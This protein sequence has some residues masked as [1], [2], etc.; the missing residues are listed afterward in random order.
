MAVFRPFRAIRPLPEYASGV[1]ELPY[2][3][4]SSDEARVRA[5][6]RPYSFLHVDKAEIDLP[7]DTDLYSEQVYRKAKE[8]MEKLISDGICAADGTPCYYIYRQIMNGRAQTGIVGCASIDDYLSGVIKRHELTRADKELDRINHVDT[9]NANT[10]P[11]FLAYRPSEGVRRIIEKYVHR[12]PVYDFT[13]D[14]VQNIVWIVSDPADDE[15]LKKA[16]AEIPALYIA[17][18]HHR[19]AS[20]VHVGQARRESHP[21]FS[22]EEE[23]NYFLAVAFDSSE[24]AIMDYNRVIRD[25]N[26]MS[27]SEFLEKLDKNFTHRYAGE[28]QYRPGRR[29]EFG[30]YLD[31]SW[32]SL[33]AKEDICNEPDPV[34]RLDVSIL[35][36]NVIDPLFGITDP[37]VD[38]R[39]D[40]IGGIRGL[41]ELERRCKTDMRVAFAMYPTSID[42]LMEIADAGELMPPKSTWFEPKLLSGLFIHSLQ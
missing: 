14:W 8:N 28:S 7:P 33:T 31:G 23:F 19:C 3:V 24:L 9:C 21:G 4:M 1:A 37:R 15:A 5:A 38:K 34:D 22:G 11:I 32:Y 27:V 16:F 35:Q 2:D 30:M 20:A 29:H 13:A 36:K 18:G 25:L 17:D 41:G 10:G 26:G 12:E 40:F 6:D 39:I 42:E